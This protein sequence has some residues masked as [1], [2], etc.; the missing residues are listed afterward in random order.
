MPTGFL[1]FGDYNNER[2]AEI[3]AESSQIVDADARFAAYD[4]AQQ[5]AMDELP[6]IPW[7]SPTTSSPCATACRATPTRAIRFIGSGR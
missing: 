1:N 4:E 6:F 2:V 5:I 3:V 7:P